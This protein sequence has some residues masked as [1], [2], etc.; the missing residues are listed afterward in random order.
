[1]LESLLEGAGELVQSVAVE[2]VPP[3]VDALDVDAVVQRVDV[4]AILE[5]VDLDA[6]LAKVDIN[7]LLE[8]VDIDALLGRTEIGALVSRS[9]SAV[10]H[11]ALDVVR[12]Q[13]VGLDAF[14]ER[15]AARLL[16]RG[17]RQEP[18]GP[19]LLVDRRPGTRPR[20]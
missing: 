11:Q 18:A 17:N 15:W 12:S 8:R 2:V 19:T 13:G 14:I 6:V 9:G 3:V 4:E 5:R 10:A 16:R 7:A 20:P 1:M